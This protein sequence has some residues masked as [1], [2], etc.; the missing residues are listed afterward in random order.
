[1]LKTLWQIFKILRWHKRTFKEFTAQKQA[2]KIAEEI[3]EWDREFFIGND[4]DKEFE[5]LADVIIASVCALRFSENMEFVA[6]KM[7]KN[8][9]RVW[10]NGHHIDRKSHFMC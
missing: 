9:K 5:E 3:L 6:E 7:E 2:E 1:M 10:K 8:K 4:I